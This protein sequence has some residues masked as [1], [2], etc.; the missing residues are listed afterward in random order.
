MR[1]TKRTITKQGH[2]V[3]SSSHSPY[4]PFPPELYQ[5]PEMITEYTPFDE[6]V[7]EGGTAQN[8]FT[9]PRIFR[10]KYCTEIVMEHKIADHICIGAQD[11]EDS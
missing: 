9:S 5:D 10:C 8:G 4:G 7:P 1:I 3:P 2:P 11:G 6:D